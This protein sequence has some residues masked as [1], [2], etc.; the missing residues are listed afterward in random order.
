MKFSKGLVNSV[1]MFKCLCSVFWHTEMQK[2]ILLL[3]KISC[4]DSFHYLAFSVVNNQ[5]DPTFSKFITEYIPLVT[6]RT[7]TTIT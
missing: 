1:Q 4:Y 6:N 7:S 3:K 2:L 5:C